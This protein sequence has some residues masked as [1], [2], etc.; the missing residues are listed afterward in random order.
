MEALDKIGRENLDVSEQFFT[1]STV[2]S[3]MADM[4]VGRDFCRKSVR[5]LDPGAGT[6]ILSVTVIDRIK[7]VSPDTS[8]DVVAVEKEPST[9]PFL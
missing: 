6:D 1:A 4:L 7:E 3:V 2:A 8:V 5:L 9:T